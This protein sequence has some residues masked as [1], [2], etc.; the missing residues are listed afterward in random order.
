[1]KIAVLAA[2][3]TALITTAGW[4]YSGFWVIKDTRQ[5]SCSIVTSNPVIDGPIGPILWGS[6]P[7][8][9]Q[10]DAELAITTIRACN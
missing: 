9:S 5:P 8:Q 3:T 7:Y 10:K 6:G 4:N 1:M 2:A